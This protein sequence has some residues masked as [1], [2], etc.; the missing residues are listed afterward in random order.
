MQ[1]L[2]AELPAHLNWQTAFF[3][4]FHDDFKRPLDVEKW[5]ALRVVN[6]AARAPGPRWNT[7]VSRRRFEDLMSVPVEYRN[8]PDALPMHAEISLQA[9]LRSFSGAQRDTVLRIKVR[10]FALTELRLAPPFGE[11]ADGYRTA[12][13]DFLG[14]QKRLAPSV[15]WDRH[16]PLVVYNAT[17]AETLKKLDA[18]DRR[19]RD[20]EARSNISLP[21]NSRAAK[22]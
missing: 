18:L 16:A 17:L 22:P 19:R 15:P 5:W 6:F 9:A 3:K 2:L 14:E 12:L 8:G 11:L 21:G 7:E 10:D 20:A 1:A 4:A 13:A